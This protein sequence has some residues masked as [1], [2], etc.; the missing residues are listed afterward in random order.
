[1]LIK[2]AQDDVSGFKNNNQWLLN[3][4]TQALIFN[5]RAE[6]FKEL[7]TTHNTDFR[8]LVYGIFPNSAEL[9]NTITT[10]IPI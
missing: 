5:Y 9:L 4:P 7:E 10:I 8:S 2:V 6:I 1:M 3:P